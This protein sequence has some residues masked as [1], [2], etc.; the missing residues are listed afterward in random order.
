VLLV[1]VAQA[2]SNV[3]VRGTIAAVSAEVLSVQ[4]RDGR[5]LKL[6]LPADAT[7]AVAK[8]ARFEDIEPGDY[9]GTM[10]NPGPDGTLVAVEVH[11]LPPTAAERHT[12]E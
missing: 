9:V 4:S 3:R 10:A 2:Q 11:Y 12:P 1:P 7:V 5:D 8:A 6:L